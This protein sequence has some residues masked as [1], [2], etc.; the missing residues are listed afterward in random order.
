MHY[1]L[2]TFSDTR[3]ELFNR[4]CASVAKTG[5][6]GTSILNVVIFNSVQKEDFQE[7][8]EGRL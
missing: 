8:F 1:T 5:K 2:H 6:L 3:D 4:L 7:C